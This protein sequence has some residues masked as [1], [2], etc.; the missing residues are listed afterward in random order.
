MTQNP[1]ISASS[2]G[3]RLS[4]QDLLKESFWYMIELSVGNIIELPGPRGET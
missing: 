1:N 2:F 3:V 4:I